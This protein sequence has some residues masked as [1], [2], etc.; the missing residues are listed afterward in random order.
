[1][2]ILV[3]L[4][5]ADA[6]NV[7]IISGEHLG[8]MSGHVLLLARRHGDL[9][10]PQSVQDDLI[11]QTENVADLSVHHVAAQ[12]LPRR[13]VDKGEVDASRLTHVLPAS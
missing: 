8:A 4:Q 13:R 11:L 3:P 1:M 12:R 7:E 9:E 10:H 6:L 5:V 2:R